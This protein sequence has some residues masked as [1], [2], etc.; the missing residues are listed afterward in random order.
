MVEDGIKIIISGSGGPDDKAEEKADKGSW[1]WIAWSWCK[2]QKRRAK[3]LTRPI[4]VSLGAALTKSG[5]VFTGC[6]VEN[7]LLT[8]HLRGEN[9]HLQGCL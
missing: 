3:S 1:A 7:A 5:K 6:N 9:R 2:R 4:P 8:D